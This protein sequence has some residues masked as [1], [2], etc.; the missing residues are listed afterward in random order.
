MRAR[1]LQCLCPQRHAILGLGVGVS[2]EE[3]SD[4]D[5]IKGFKAVIDA[6]LLGQHDQL[7]S[8]KL[9]ITSLPAWCGLCGAPAASWSIEIGWMKP[10]ADWNT[11]VAALR[12]CEAEQQAGRELMNLLGLTY[13]A[14]IPK[15]P[16]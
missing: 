5:A 13:D 3:L 7:E 8:F 10:Q 1:I 6:L 11:A 16:Q 4:L 9:P 2:Q 12:E 14:T 15:R